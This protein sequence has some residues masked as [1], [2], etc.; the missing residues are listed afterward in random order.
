[1]PANCGSEWKGLCGQYGCER[2]QRL[3]RSQK[4]KSFGGIGKWFQVVVALVKKLGCGENEGKGGVKGEGVHISPDA[5]SVK[6][7][8]LREPP[9]EQLV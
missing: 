8:S 3:S 6:H 5:F 1:M 2:W 4:A 9:A 7:V